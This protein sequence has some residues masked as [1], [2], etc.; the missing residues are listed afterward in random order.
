MKWFY[1]LTISKKL[2]LSFS[3]VLA[4]SIAAGIFSIHQ[5]ASLN[6]AT[7]EI[8]AR[9]L[10]GVSLSLEIKLALEGIRTI[11]LEQLHAERNE[12]VKA[13]EANSD[14]LFT[15]VRAN[16]VAYRLLIA[17]P[18]EASVFAQL[19]QV[20]G[21]FVTAHRNIFEMSS[22]TRGAGEVARRAA[23][24]VYQKM[25][26]IVDRLVAINQ[27]AGAAASQNAKRDYDN[28]RVLITAALG[29]CAALGAGLALWL[30]RIVAR[31]L[32][33]AVQVA[34][35]VAAGDLSAGLRSAQRVSGGE[36]GHL[37]LALQTMT[38]GLRGIV[39]KVRAGTD[40]IAAI[41]GEIAAGNLN[42]S[43]RTEEQADS[44]GRT[45][46]AMEQLTATVQ[47]NADNAAAARQ[48]ASSAS[49]V[50]S[51]GGVAM[52][53]VEATM[54]S[55]STSSRKIVDIISV[56]DGIAFQ[57]NI[58]ALNAAVEAARA[59]EQGRGFAVVASEV[60]SLAQRSASAAR[61]IKQLIADSAN[62]IDEGGKLVAAAGATM[63]VVVDSVRRVNE[64][65]DDISNASQEQGKG[66]EQIN[67]AIARMDDMT[68]QNAALVEQAAAA[69]QSMRDQAAHLATLVSVFRL[70]AAPV[71][72]T[73]AAPQPR[74]A[75]HLLAHGQ[76]G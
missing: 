9:R 60:R 41:S 2:L 66:I 76:A 50:A 42:L 56:I 20:L 72:P 70:D 61:E 47:N 5:L 69:T 11:Q 36:T 67:V 39:G 17:T 35:Q 23:I 26:A 1:A 29:A 57:T 74:N 30:A 48:L 14:K 62:E 55:I 71:L 18:E 33:E 16:M 7:T 13:N 19:E 44:L 25:F 22:V 28:S 54:Q 24:P 4:L 10:P 58:L 49:S 34:Q 27:D 6:Q 63:L 73:L 45:V 12:D 15:D 65:V 51:E 37:L 32:Y 75:S 64:I 43:S 68:Q 40:A 52:H 21:Q 53:R 59:G 46:T 31:P 3:L 8:A 38:E